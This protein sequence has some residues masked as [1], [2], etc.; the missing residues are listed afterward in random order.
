MTPCPCCGGDRNKDRKEIVRLVHESGRFLYETI[1][2]G[3][4][5]LVF[6]SKFPGFPD[7]ELQL[8]DQCNACDEAGIRKY[9]GVPE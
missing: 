1:N 6:K 5:L 7:K 8:G 9:L 4:R 2:P 3:G